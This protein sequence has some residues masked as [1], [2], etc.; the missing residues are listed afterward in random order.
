MISKCLSRRLKAAAICS[1][2]VLSTIPTIFPMS[3]KTDSTASVSASDVELNYAKA[4]Q[5]SM[6]FYD[7]NM[8]GTGVE[9]NSEYSWRGNCHVYDEKLPL[10]SVN[11]NMSD[12]FIKANKDVLD[13]DGDGCLDVAGGYH[14]AGDHVK[15]GMPEGYSGAAVGWG[16]YEFRDAYE[17]TG[18]AEHAETI[19]RYFND[20]FMKCTYLDKSG[21]AIAF[22][23]QV[24]DGDID[25]RYW[26]SPEVDEMFRRGWFATDELVSTDCLSI[27]ASSLAIN[28]MNFKDTD[29][30]YAEKNLDYAKALFEFADRASKKS[31]NNDGPKS[32]YESKKWEDDY[33]FA[34]VW[35]Y[36]ATQ[37]DEYVNKALNYV[38]YYAP[39]CWTFCWNDVWAGVMCLLGEADTMYG[40][41]VT[42]SVGRP[43][44]EFAEKFKTLQNK[45]PYEDVDWWSQIAKTIENWENGVTGQV[46][47]G[48]YS[49]LNKWGS[50]RYNTATQF[51]ALV[52]DKH[53]GGKATGYSEWAK[54]QMDY[55]L[56]KNPMNR[57]YVVG[58]SDISAKY[59]HHRASSGLSKCEDRGEQR[60]VLYGA[61]VGGP[62][63]GDQHIDLTED[64][65]YNEVTIDYNAAFVG[66]CAGNY[67]FFG[68]ESM[69]VTPDFPPEVSYNPGE[70]G[71]EGGNR[72][73]AEGFCVDIAQSDGPKA[74]EIT[75]FVC[76]NVTKPS[77]NISVRYYFDS[78]GMSSVDINSI[79]LRQ[80]YDQTAAETDF[81]ATISKAPVHYKDKIY[82]IEIS[83]D[84]FV[85]AN[86][87]K[88][89][90]FDLGT[91]AWGNSWNPDDDWSHKDLKQET[92]AFKGTPEVAP[93]IC[94]YDNGVLV[95]GTEPDGT[96]PEVVTQTPKPTES[97]VTTTPKTTTTKNT[98]TAKITTTP[99]NTTTKS[100]PDDIRYGD[101]DSNGKVEITDLTML[102]QYL[103]GDMTFNADTLKRADVNG[104]GSV[105]LPDLSH[106]KQYIM[107]DPVTL[108]P[109]KK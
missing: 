61:L 5:Y 35:L 48:G 67:Y 66:A 19:L 44:T 12:S 43:S 18:Q 26:N 97:T 55:L 7:A 94:I 96:V 56:G 41:K 92:D 79:E 84:G 87:N 16:Y 60:Y 1:A 106:F 8:C 11:T 75:F 53:N 62:D 82:Y 70:D 86:S 14:D 29:P 4:L 108:G 37:D 40:K 95:G 109:V 49:F 36:M 20:Y 68:D 58:Y 13:P 73:W 39:S 90:Q 45:S 25:H 34:A 63:E 32:Y 77:K 23:Y 42:N 57:C 59:P 104:D 15:F 24:G 52:Y 102:S 6:Y 72:Y 98:T 28:Y 100:T 50:A 65:I 47:P 80:L 46:T 105:G 27:A 21:K 78:T 38:D 85:I 83:W 51:L 22:C 91:Y 54:S 89:Y 93:Y 76:S 64:W 81:K 107:H 74:T 101:L 99:D 31:V 30:E 9:E 103:L 17:A 33:C 88:K 2:F 3:G 71:P 10:D 69:Q